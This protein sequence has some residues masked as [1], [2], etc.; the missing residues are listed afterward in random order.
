MQIAGI[1]G[2]D[3]VLLMDDHHFVEPSFIQLLNS[4]LSA[5]EVPGLY[6]AEELDHLLGPLREKAAD[7]GFRGIATCA[8]SRFLDW[9]RLGDNPDLLNTHTLAI[10]GSSLNVERCYC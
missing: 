6:A 2:E 8:Q 7:D 3:V 1:D 10:A 5:G 4:L 9:P